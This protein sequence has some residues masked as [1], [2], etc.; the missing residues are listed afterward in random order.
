MPLSNILSSGINNLN[1]TV[2]NATAGLQSFDVNQF[3][4]GLTRGISQ[5][6]GGLSQAGGLLQQA[7]GGMQQLSGNLNNV[8]GGAGSALS[9]VN[10]QLP[11][12]SSA[13]T[14][15]ERNFQGTIE[16]LNRVNI[17]ELSNNITQ[18]LSEIARLPEISGLFNQDRISQTLNGIRQNINVLPEAFNSITT[19]LSDVTSAVNNLSSSASSI[20]SGARGI[21]ENISGYDDAILRQLRLTN[22]SGGNR[23][24]TP[25]EFALAPS[26]TGDGIALPNPLR[27]YASYTYNLEL[28]VLSPYEI[29]SPEDS[30]RNGLSNSIVRS[31]GGNYNNRVTTFDED[32]LGKHAEYYIDDLET[33]TLASPN[34]DTGL[35]PGSTIRFT[36]TEPYSMGKFLEALAI[37]AN[38]AGYNSYI[39]APYVLKITFKGYDQNGRILLN[40]AAPA[41]FMPIKL[42]NIEFEVKS[43]GS[44]YQVEAIPYNEI[45][46]TSQASSVRTDVNLTGRTVIENLETGNTATPQSPPLTAILNGRGETLAEAGAY[47]TPDRYIIMFPTDSQGATRA[48]TAARESNFSGVSGATTGVTE[49]AAAQLRASGDLGILNRIT[50]NQTQI[51]PDGSVYETLRRYAATN[52][53]IIGQSPLLDNVLQDGDRTHPRHDHSYDEFGTVIRTQVE[54]GSDATAR[55]GMYTRNTSIISIIEDMVLSSEYGRNITEQAQ[56]NAAEGLREWFRIETQVFIEEDPA[57]QVQRGTPPKIYVYSV[58]PYFPDESSFQG[59]SRR[60]ANTQSQ[61]NLSLKE[62][63]YYYTGLNEDVLD[64]RIEFKT[65]FFQ[66]L[67]ADL[68]QL[69]TSQR[70]GGA[71][72][73]VNPNALDHTSTAPPGIGPTSGGTLAEPS[74]PLEE[75]TGTTDSARGGMRG[76]ASIQA[77]RN[78]AQQFHDTLINSNVDM[79]NA[80]MEIWGDPYWIPESGM[81]NYNAAPSGIHP[82]LT[83]DG[84]VTGQHS[85]ITVL[86][87]FRTPF[88]YNQDAGRMQFS[89]VV[90]PFSGVY[91]VTR[92]ENKFSGGKFTQTLKMI[93]KRGQNDEAT[94]ATDALQLGGN[95]LDRTQSGAA[96]SGAATAGQPNNTGVPASS[97]GGG[98]GGTGS[99]AAAGSGPNGERVPTATG[100]TLSTIRTSIRG[101]ETQVATLVAPN[102]QGLIDELE[103]EYGYEIRSLGGYVDRYIRGTTTKSWH[104][105]GIAIDINP[106]PDNADGSRLT[107]NLPY[108]P[109]GSEMVA[110]AAKYGLGW[111]GAWTGGYFDAMHFSAATGEQGTFVVQR[112]VIP[113]AAPSTTPTPDT[114]GTGTPTTGGTDPRAAGPQ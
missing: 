105:S 80:E 91:Q 20:L 113:A 23:S 112:G 10:A 52:V 72:E 2:S 71:G 96:A 25:T 50:A 84:G 107:T 94:G 83:V 108:P 106:Y 77:K 99:S 49:T 11:Q 82:N 76:S 88:D 16:N 65:A 15:L 29:N 7:N 67:F 62:Y 32:V 42:T 17:V 73:V 34:P 81:G 8:L 100:G 45:A 12:F 31:G 79:V 47:N 14:D 27:E 98:G 26:S 102:L 39:E 69:S 5:L 9:R 30:Y 60:S 19:G 70:I 61:R 104:A 56:A 89:D 51:I 63:N 66:N 21:F 44:M 78:I 48:V 59:P 28:S 90:K 13:F 87:N 22:S 40:T 35:T 41:K 57:T 93:R 75:I 53:N 58:V 6:Q 114:S 109:N 54:A 95:P 33:L 68:G 38:Q 85:T 74:P 43:Q 110:L 92:I 55:N 24:G 64:F 97:A 4:T 111:G 37:G 101:L 86:V 36:I 1:R 3:N 103:Q 46:L 18:P